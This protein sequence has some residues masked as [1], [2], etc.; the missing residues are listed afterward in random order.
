MAATVLQQK[1]AL[2]VEDVDTASPMEATKESLVLTDDLLRAMTYEPDPLEI[3]Y[4]RPL[5][6]Q[7][8]K[9][10]AMLAA[11]RAETERLPDGTWYAEIRNFPGVWAQGDSEE[12]AI[13]DVET[14]VRDW[15]LLKIQDKDRNLPIIAEINL[16]VL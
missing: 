14:V 2:N 1:P 5:P 8:I 6:V 15:T 4:G 10:Y 9:T 16:N 13:K 3:R 12:E 11:Q 7:L